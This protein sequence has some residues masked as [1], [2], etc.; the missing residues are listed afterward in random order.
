MKKNILLALFITF[1]AAA[2]VHAGSDP[3]LNNDGEIDGDYTCNVTIAGG[4][5]FTATIA[6]D[7]H[8][9]GEEELIVAAEAST[10]QLWGTGNGSLSGTTF[11]GTT[12]FAKPFNLTVGF[13]DS[14]GT[15][16]YDQ[17]TLNGTFGLASQVAT[18]SCTSI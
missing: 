18:L 15:G 1:A 13:V 10:Q 14:K 17:L 8:A 5:P 11:S 7:G 3:T 9:N 12:S 4:T 2:L 16:T 6:V